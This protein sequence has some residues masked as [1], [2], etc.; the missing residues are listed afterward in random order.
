MSLV[1]DSEKREQAETFVELL[2]A[3]I[4]K[5]TPA[6]AARVREV[7]YQTLADPTDAIAQRRWCGEMK[8][9]FPRPGD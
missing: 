2:S 1:E 7:T 9:L 3:A 5:F 8:K 4:P 6:D